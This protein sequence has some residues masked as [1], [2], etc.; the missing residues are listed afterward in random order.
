MFTILIL[1]MQLLTECKTSKLYGPVEENVFL[2][3]ISIYLYPE[4]NIWLISY[5]ISSSVFIA[6]SGRAMRELQK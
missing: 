4:F 2:A 3:N 1:F 6:N 5:I